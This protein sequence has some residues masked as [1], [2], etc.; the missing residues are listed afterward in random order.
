MT[1]FSDAMF[2]FVYFFHKLWHLADVSSF[3]LLVIVSPYHIPD[4]QLL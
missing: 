1:A 3:S 4:L 2:S